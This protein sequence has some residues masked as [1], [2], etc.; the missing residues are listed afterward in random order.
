M[1]H[2]TMKTLKFALLAMAFAAFPVLAQG[3]H[4]PMKAT[5]DCGACCKQGGDCCPK[6]GHDK[7]ASCCDKKAVPKKEAPKK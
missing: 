4:K 7:C 1:K 6:C 5:K 3:T 2:T